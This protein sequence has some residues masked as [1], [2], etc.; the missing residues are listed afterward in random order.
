MAVVINTPWY[1]FMNTKGID[2]SK[3]VPEGYGV[4]GVVV[5]TSIKILL[6]G[7]SAAVILATFFSLAL[8]SGIYPALRASRVPPVESMKMA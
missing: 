5:D 4:S 1:V 2:L 8:L 6:Y 3:Y 7:E